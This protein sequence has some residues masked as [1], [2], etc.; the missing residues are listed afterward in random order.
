MR[1][2]FELGKFTGLY[3]EE[4]PG[5]V[6]ADNRVIYAAP[7]FGNGF[8]FT[9]S[10]DW[11]K[12][13]KDEVYAIVFLDRSQYYCIGYT[14][15]YSKYSDFGDYPN[16][17]HI[18]TEKFIVRFNDKKDS[19]TVIQRDGSNKVTISKEDRV[20]VE[21]TENIL[22]KNDEGSITL[23]ADGVSVE[24]DKAINIKDGSSSIKIAS[25]GNEIDVESPT[26]KLLGKTLLEVEEKNAVPSGTG[27]L[28]A[29]PSCIFSG[30]VHVGNKAM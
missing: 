10:E 14:P 17:G 21:T 27:A 15:I 30:A 1:Q 4:C 3:E 2:N 7:V 28:C 6:L 24:T 11:I 26:L 19:I 13:Y 9:P 22:L 25:G 18:R 23:D 20:V 8:M 12:K 16:E 5:I 29:I